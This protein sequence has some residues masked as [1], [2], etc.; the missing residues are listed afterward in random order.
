MD[1]KSYRFALIPQR[2]RQGL[3]RGNKKTV[4]HL[5]RVLLRKTGARIQR[6]EK[7]GSYIYVRLLLPEEV[8]AQRAIA[9]VKHESAAAL[10]AR[11]KRAGLDVMYGVRADKPD[12]WCSSH[13]MDLGA[14]DRN[15]GDM[16]T[17]VGDALLDRRQR[18]QIAEYARKKGTA[19]IRG[20][21]A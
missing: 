1:M 7:T 6:L 19:E 5:L 2:Q 8:D 14:D 4:E 3:Y 12:F 9:W 20:I 10:Y 11:L 18:E 15:R 16:E 17:F 13:Y 21:G